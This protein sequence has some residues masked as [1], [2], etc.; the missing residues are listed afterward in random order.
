[1]TLTIIVVV[2]IVGVVFILGGIASRPGEWYRNLKKPSWNPPNW[3]FGPAWTI[4]LSLA[5]AAG[6]FAWTAAADSGEQTRVAVLF[7]INIFFYVIWSPLFFAAKRPDWALAEVPFLWL[8]ILALIVGLWDISSTASWLL[9]PFLLW[10]TF[11]AF[12]NWRIVRLN[13]P[14]GSKA[15]ASHTLHGEHARE[16]R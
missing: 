13:A 9:V 2:A 10:V 8:S 16:R 3:A 4:I 15:E 1:M 5:G 14:F 11:A 12:L 7:A 6:V